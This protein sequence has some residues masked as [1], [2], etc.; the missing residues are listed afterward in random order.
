MLIAFFVAAMSV[1]IPLSFCFWPFDF[2]QY[3]CNSKDDNNIAFVRSQ[4]ISR[5][6]FG[7]RACIWWQ[8]SSA[9]ARHKVGIGFRTAVC[10]RCER[11]GRPQLILDHKGL[12]ICILSTSY[13]SF[14]FNSPCISRWKFFLRQ[15]AHGE[16]CPQGTPVRSGQVLHRT[17]AAGRAPRQ[18][19]V[20]PASPPP[21]AAPSRA[22]RSNR[23]R[24][25]QPP[26]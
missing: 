5:C 12:P 23:H 10:D 4:R 21:Q 14:L 6:T 26:R 18:Q 3:V 19:P 25:R 20:R 16:H 7:A 9:L 22:F 13:V 2:C 15:A 17:H 8:F 24:G 11:Y 1:R